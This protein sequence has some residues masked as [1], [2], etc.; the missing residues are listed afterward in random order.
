MADKVRSSSPDSPVTNCACSVSWL[1]T[2]EP[3]PMASSNP[4]VLGAGRSSSLSAAMARGASS[5]STS[6]RNRP[7]T[8]GIRLFLASNSGVVERHDHAIGLPFIEPARNRNRA[9]RDD[10]RRTTKTR[11]PSPHPHGRPYGADRESAQ[12][13]ERATLLLRLLKPCGGDVE[14]GVRGKLM[15]RMRDRDAA[16]DPTVGRIGRDGHTYRT[17]ILAPRHRR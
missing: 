6:T 8:R 3:F 9:P 13:H 12:R 7:S 5:R 1:G 17:P 2:S 15:P 14:L 16:R 4:G 10:Q 11:Q